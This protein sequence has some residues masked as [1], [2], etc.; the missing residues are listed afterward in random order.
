[1]SRAEETAIALEEVCGALPGGGGSGA[2]EAWTR[3]E[4]TL[5]DG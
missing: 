4:E 5:Q 3:R 1:M 2:N